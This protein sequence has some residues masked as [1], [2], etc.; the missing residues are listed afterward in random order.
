MRAGTDG[1]RRKTTK[2]QGRRSVE[3]I[4]Q[5]ESAMA[6]PN[7]PR[8]QK[9]AV[10][11]LDLFNPPESVIVFQ[12]NPDALARVLTARGASGEGRMAEPTRIA[13][14]G[15]RDIQDNRT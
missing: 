3:T 6:F 13:S 14:G 15:K 7:S 8:L 10:V 5:E 4:G 11:G 1:V 9:G 12:F 2:G